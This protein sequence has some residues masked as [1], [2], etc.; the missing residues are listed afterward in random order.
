MVT[1]VENNRPIYL[2]P[3]CN[4]RDESGGRGV[5]EYG[6]FLFFSFC[7]FPVSSSEQSKS[8][9]LDDYHCYHCVSV[10]MYSCIVAR[11]SRMIP[12]YFDLL[13]VTPL[14]H[15]YPLRFLYLMLLFLPILYVV[16][17]VCVCVCVW[18]VSVSFLSK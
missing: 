18:R 11:S 6:L 9:L 1:F 3:F 4:E 5:R 13:F 16:V 2:F 15:S 17:P 14:A 8:I 12:A 10:Y 7:F